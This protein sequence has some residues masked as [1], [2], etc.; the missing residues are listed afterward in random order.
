M[1]SAGTQLLNALASGDENISGLLRHTDVEASLTAGED[2]E[3]RVETAGPA[4]A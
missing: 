2:N 3:E 4:L 1:L